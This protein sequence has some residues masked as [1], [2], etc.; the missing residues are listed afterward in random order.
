MGQT[1]GIIR[2]GIQLGLASFQVKA[3]R[4]IGPLKAQVTIE[5][6]HTDELVITDHPIEQGAVIT[7]HA[8][9]RPAEVTIKCMWS[10]S[11]SRAGFI[12]GLVGAVTGTIDGVSSILSGSGV[13]QIR[14]IYRQL[15]DL[16]ESRQ[17]FTL[18]TGKREYKDMLIRSLSQETTKDTENA[19]MITVVCRQLILVTTQ[20]V[21]VTAPPEA[22][23][24]PGVTQP[25][26]NQG[27]K[28][29]SPASSY[30]VGAG[31]GFVNPPL[32]GQ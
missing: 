14:D 19:L 10:N 11:P 32:I 25:P 18:N 26:S 23:A 5:E 2:T 31:R 12:D 9:K 15:V 1:L 3:Q 16:Q 22:Q 13:D 29:L 21:T 28:Q 17:R 30:N 4:N 7:D 8:F 24:N 6:T 20:V 27:T